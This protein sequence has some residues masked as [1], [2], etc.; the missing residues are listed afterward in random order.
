[1]YDR[2]PGHLQS[3]ESLGDR[4]V[5]L[6]Y[7]DPSTGDLGTNVTLLGPE[8]TP[9]WSYKAK[10]PA[11]TLRFDAGE[12]RLTLLEGASSQ[13]PG[14]GWWGLEIDLRLSDGQPVP[15]IKEDPA[16]DLGN[17]RYLILENVL[18]RSADRFSGDYRKSQA[19]IRLEGT[20]V[21]IRDLVRY[22]DHA[23]A[24]P[25]FLAVA[26]RTAEGVKVSVLRRAEC[27]R[28]SA[29]K[30]WGLDRRLVWQ[31]AYRINRFSLEPDFVMD[32]W[33]GADSGVANARY[34]ITAL[35]LLPNLCLQF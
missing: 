14:T 22:T 25:D 11:Y 32:V 4:T 27:L 6:S 20:G 21:S 7:T 24:G 3:M 33:A 28:Y 31:V 35:D 8:G 17:Y 9:E 30:E 18:Y 34:D 13:L 16:A 26:C 5:V 29:A 10:G 1:M 15:G 2:L 23:L 19:V 12:E